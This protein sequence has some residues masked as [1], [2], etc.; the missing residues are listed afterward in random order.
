LLLFKNARILLQG[1]DDFAP[2]QK[3]EAAAA[4]NDMLTGG[5]RPRID[6]TFPLTSIAEAHD[7]LEERARGRV[8]LTLAGG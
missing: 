8:V 4:T 7:Y 2:D 3:I 6:K 1:S 5:F